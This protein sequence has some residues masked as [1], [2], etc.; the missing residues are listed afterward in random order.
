MKSPEPVLT[1][2]QIKGTDKTHN[3]TP[4]HIVTLGLRIPLF[5]VQNGHATFN[6]SHIY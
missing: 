6:S 5:Q 1:Y 3:F 4:F 2:L